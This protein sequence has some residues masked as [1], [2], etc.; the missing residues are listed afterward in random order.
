MSDETVAAAR[1]ESCLADLTKAY[2]DCEKCGL[3]WD[4]LD[5][6]PPA[7]RPMTFGRIRARLGAEID[8]AMSSHDRLVGM[9]AEGIKQAN[10][11]PE[12]SRAIEL[13]AILRFIDRVSTNEAILDILNPRRKAA[14]DD[15]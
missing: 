8:R 2:P 6:N 12:L 5:P 4:A 15:G 10:P 9:R 7:C 11:M 14:R 3:A 13:R 1:P